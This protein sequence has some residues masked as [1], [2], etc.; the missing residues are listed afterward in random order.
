MTKRSL[1]AALSVMAMAS[2]MFA[3]DKPKPAAQPGPHPKSNLEIAALNKMFSAQTPDDR[4]AAGEEVIANFE[5]TEFKSIVFF[6]IADAYRQKDDDVK[7]VVYGERALEA[8][9][10]NYQAS[11]LLAQGIARKV[12]ENDLDRDERLNTAEKYANQALA[13]IPDAIKMNANMTDDQWADTKKD[14]MA[15]AHQALG[16]I[17]MG[18]KKWD[19]AVTEYTAAVTMAHTPDPVAMVRLAQADNKIG[20]YDD[21]IMYADKV[22][23]I[24]KIPASVKQV[25]QAERVRAFG[26]KAAAAK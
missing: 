4:I 7:M 23:A 1:A 3:Q 8:D 21:A 9:P 20:K 13:S 25:A 2:V 19:V 15:D 12:R 5:K 24:E 10:K 18:R 6:T 17:A 26:A 16:I 11:L 14:L 22:M